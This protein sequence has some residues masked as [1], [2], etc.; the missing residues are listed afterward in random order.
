MRP[1]RA[2]FWIASTEAS[3]PLFPNHDLDFHFG[4]EI[5]DIFGA[6]IKFGMAFLAAEALGFGDGDALDADFLQGFF[7]FVELER[8]DDGFDFFHV[9]LRPRGLLRRSCSLTKLQDLCRFLPKKFV[10]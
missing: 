2:A 9:L 6:A 8:F 1:V 10:M 7:H 5:H 3:R 4:Q